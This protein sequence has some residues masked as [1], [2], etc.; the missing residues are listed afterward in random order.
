ME[1]ENSVRGMF[2]ITSDPD[3]T[4]F[5]PAA[6]A[7]ATPFS[8]VPLRLL[9]VADLCPH[10]TPAWDA[11][12][13]V[14]T[15]DKHQFAPWLTACAPTLELEVAN[16]LDAEPALLTVSLQFNQLRDF[17]PDQVAQQVPGLARL[18]QIRGLVEQVAERALSVEA[19][20]GHLE[21]LGIDAAWAQRLYQ[22]LLASPK[23]PS[24]SAPPSPAGSEALDRLLGMVDLGEAQPPTPSIAD[25][26]AQA[27]AG[28]E[29]TAVPAAS[30]AGAARLIDELNTVLARQVEAIIEHPAFRALE[31]AWRGLKLLV[32]RLDFRQGLQLDVLPAAKG[33]LSEALYA[34]VLM[35]EHQADLADHVP[36]TAILLDAAFT[37]DA[38]DLALLEDLAETGASL[39]V[40]VVGGVQPSF[41]GVTQATGLV[42]LP[43]L[44]QHLAGPAYIGWEKLRQRA[45]TQ[46]LALALPAV[47]LRAP[48]TAA[49]AVGSLALDTSA[50]LWGGGAI[51]VALALGQSFAQ[52]D[53]PT[54]LQTGPAQGLTDWPL[55]P[56]PDGPSP[57]PVRL[58]DGKV[59]ELEDAGFV[60]IQS[61]RHSDVLFLAATPMVHRPRTHELGVARSQG[62]VALSTVLFST[63]VAQ[64]LLSLQGRKVLEGVARAQAAQVLAAQFRAWMRGPTGDLP[65]DAVVITDLQE[66]EGVDALQIRLHPPPHVLRSGT[67]LVLRWPI[68]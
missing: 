47:L 25:R 15:V 66:T 9:Y 3:T 36:L 45:E 53:W 32:D 10:R 11:T 51:A 35:P 31:A 46:Y 56:A 22:T 41:F 42:K 67:P 20:R 14:E 26:M 62:T 27:L 39:Q 38:A 7:E 49:S 48:Y 55:W 50:P 8:A 6:K 64:F 58:P 43:L 2:R 12:S 28:G 68:A 33:E 18:L 16:R 65:D 60:V 1:K 21:A 23:R 61:A 4:Q 54:H 57:L 29:A 30:G 19:F 24:A 44:W 17:A 34:Q 5:A 40:P 63:R 52:T 59:E 13:Y 37:N